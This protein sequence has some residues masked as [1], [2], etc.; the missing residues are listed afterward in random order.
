MKFNLK[1]NLVRIFSNQL[2]GIL[3]LLFLLSGIL[4][5]FKLGSF[6]L[7]DASEAT[8]GEFI[9][10]IIKTGDWITMHYNGEILFDKPPL[11]FW[12]ATLA[13]Y[14]FGFNE[15]ALRFWAAVA[16]VLTVIVTFFI[17]KVFYNAR[18]GF[19]SAVVLMTSFQY[20]V[21]SRIAIMDILL[22]LFLSLVF[23]FFYLGYQSLRPSYFR[24]SY[25]ALALAVLTKGLIG[26]ALPVMAIALFLFFK[27]ELRRLHKFEI[28]PGIII[29]LIVAA[30]WYL[31]EW[32]LHG[33]K[34]VQFVLGF[35]F[36]SR[37]QTA[38]EGQ[39]G[40][41]YYYFLVL[42]LG[43]APW[44]Q[45]LP[46]SL[47]RTWK[48]RAGS[49]E[50][51]SL[52][53]LIPT[54][55]VFSIANTKLPNY[56]LPLYPFTALAVGKL[57]DDF[58]N[59]TDILRKG[60]TVAN[61]LLSVIVALVIIGV[62]IFGMNYAD[63]YRAMIPALSFL[64]AVLISG[65]LISVC[66]YLFGSYKLSFA[67]IPIMVFVITAILTIQILPMVETYKGVKELA[68]EVSRVIKPGESLAAFDTGNRPSVVF[69]NH[70]PI[71]FLLNEHEVISFL[72]L[73][74][75]YCFTS[76]SQSGRFKPYAKVFDQK[77][78][79]AVLH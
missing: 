41:W 56:I 19:L 55:V 24:L 33:E 14:I 59:N 72:N 47:W 12:L 66:L 77:G 35:M 13:T 63:S 64:A 75:G 58:L 32:F 49:A 31:A 48:N 26:L 40:P 1:I 16:G 42:L 79:M 17:G 61:L 46:S 6:S 76:V 29:I 36:I 9:K 18:S 2:A 27:G 30:P 45:Y 68:G 21:Q 4:F 34:F 74:K 73:K 54:F 51:L 3:T 25:L 60:M 70:K 67:V 71:V 52:C 5:F 50:L 20:L 23:L 57:W 78:E 38:V 7:Y 22:V 10:Q 69:Y 44:G 37:F 62:I 43:F 8:Y 53:Y 39:A 28:L 65:G 11:Y 15:F